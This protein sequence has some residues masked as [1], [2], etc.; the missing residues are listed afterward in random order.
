[1]SKWIKCSDELPK[2]GKL[3]LVTDGKGWAFAWLDKD[4]LMGYAWMDKNMRHQI[5]NIT[6]WMP[7][8][9]LPKAPKDE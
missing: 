1:M 9:P 7:L 6:H 2:D 3:H 5:K 4:F 8:P